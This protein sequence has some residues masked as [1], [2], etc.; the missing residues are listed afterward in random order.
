[1]IYRDN[2]IFVHVPKTG[3]QSISMAL[4]GK[5][6]EHPTHT[7]LFA[8]LQGNRFAF[9]FVRNPW[10]RMVSLYHFLCQKPFRKTDNFNQQ[11]VRETGFKR[12]LMEDDFF[13]AEDTTAVQ[14]MQRRPQLWWLDGADFI[15]KFEDLAH[16]FATACRLGGITGSRL[17][18]INA[19]DHDDYHAYY[20]D[21]SREFVAQHFAVDIAEFG[22]R[23]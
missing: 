2:I 6:S 19:S 15:G 21:E 13:M 17:G 12:W 11:Q 14:P 3:G 8:V 5:S 18:S 20:D 1:M 7:P 22:Y 4:G 16:D 9:G 10:D 23:F